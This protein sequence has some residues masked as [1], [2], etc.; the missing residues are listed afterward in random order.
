VV[1]G[2]VV[3]EGLAG[4]GNGVLEVAC[5]SMGRGE[6]SGGVT[7]KLGNYENANEG[8]GDGYDELFV[9]YY[10][11][12]DDKFRGMPN[13]G[14]NLGGRDVSRPGSAWAGQAA[15]RDIAS[16]GYFYSGLQPYGENGSREL[17]MGF[18]SY[19]LD[20]YDQWGDSYEVQKHIPI[21]VGEWHCVERH[22]KLN[23]VSAD[24]KANMDGVEELWVDGQL[25][26]H[27]AVRFRKTPVLRIT[28]FALGM[29]YHALPKE[30]DAEHPI[31]VYFDNLVIAREYIG[32]LGGKGVA[33]ASEHP[34]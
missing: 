30:Y 4:P 28:F 7:L 33:R 21:K 22:M 11:K 3:G 23:S 5:W 6:A 27:K 12:F 18:Y 10:I 17:E 2:K 34:N 31:K 19:H 13:H 1:P 14:A 9:R 16:R 25:S 20:K 32:P 24:G 29:Y 26:I 15:I 8:R